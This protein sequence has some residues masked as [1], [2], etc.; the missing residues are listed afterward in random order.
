[1]G[2]YEIE[3]ATLKESETKWGA[4]S[5]HDEDKNIVLKIQSEGNPTPDPVS[6]LTPFIALGWII[7]LGY[8]S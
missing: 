6:I 1:M 3:G 5:A 4:P 7:F 2:R 8:Q